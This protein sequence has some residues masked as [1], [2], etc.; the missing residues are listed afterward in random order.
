MS[1]SYSTDGGD[2]W[3]PPIELGDGPVLADMD[4][5][6]VEPDTDVLDVLVTDMELGAE[7]LQLVRVADGLVIDRHVVDVDLGTG[8]LL[9]ASP[10]ALPTGE[11]L[12][13]FQ[14]SNGV[15]ALT[16]GSAS[17]GPIYVVSSEDKGL[18]WS[19]PRVIA[20]ESEA[21]WPEVVAEPDGTLRMLLVTKTGGAFR[22]SLM[23]SND[24]GVSWSSSS[25]GS[26]ELDGRGGPYP[27]LEVMGSNAIGVLHYSRSY[28]ADG[29]PLTTEVLRVSRDGGATWSTEQ[30]GEPFDHTTV[31][32]F[33]EVEDAGLGLFTGLGSS[34]CGFVVSAV[35][36][37]SQA[38]EGPTDVFVQTFAVP[39]LPQAG[40][41]P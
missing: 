4:M 34:S 10:V 15:R 32:Y 17:E 37:G 13:L 29:R 14:K 6:T 2:S 40:C 28:D 19:D 16:A 26:Y 38:T 36:G 1:L 8:S 20:P 21:L 11:I 12:V 25:I 9:Q 31:P 23:T 18:T 35:L 41:R 39:G 27:S 7:V 33:S 22:M 3:L 5:A 30:I 24:L